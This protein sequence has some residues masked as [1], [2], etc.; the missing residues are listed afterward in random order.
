MHEY[1]LDSTHFYNPHR[2]E[3]G[4]EEGGVREGLFSSRTLVG[5][6]EFTL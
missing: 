4:G 5:V 1:E 2:G 6:E 3:V